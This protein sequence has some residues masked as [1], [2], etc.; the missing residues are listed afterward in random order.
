MRRRGPAGLRNVGGAGQTAALLDLLLKASSLGAKGCHATLGTVL[1]RAQPGP[2]RCCHL[3]V[4]R[5]SLI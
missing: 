5:I 4:Q 2:T 3:R 1:K